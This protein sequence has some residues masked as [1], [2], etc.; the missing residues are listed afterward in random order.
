MGLIIEDRAHKLKKRK[1]KLTQHETEKEM[2]RVSGPW[3]T[4]KRNLTF[5][6]LEY[7]MER[8]KSVGMKENSDT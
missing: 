8:G 6:P 1:I 2:N 3:G 4:I 5:V 7:Q